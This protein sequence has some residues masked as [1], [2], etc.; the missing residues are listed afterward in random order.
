[1]DGQMPLTGNLYIFGDSLS[2]DG[3]TAT[4]TGQEP[5]PFPFGGRASNGLVWHEYIRNDLAVAPAAST[6]SAAPD[7][8]GLLGGSALNGVN[9]AHGGA[10]ASS[11]DTP[12][13]PGGVQQAEG[14]TALVEAGEIPVPDDQDVFVIWIGGNDFLR[15]A[16]VDLSDIFD[17]LTTGASV[18]GHIA[19]MV[20]TLTAVGA[21]N[22][23]VV[24]LPKAG[25]AFLGAEAADN[26]ILATI[27]NELVA[28][29]NRRLEDYVDG[30]DLNALFV[31]VASLIDAV[32]DDPAAFGFSNVSSDIFTDDAEIDD[33]SYFSVDGIHPTSA[34]HAVIANYIRD[35]AAAAGFDLTAEAGNVLP[36]SDRDDQLT[37][38]MGDDSLTG[39]AGD[40]V[41]DGQ[42]GAD[43]AFFAGAQSQFTLAIGPSLTLEDRSGAEGTDT[44]SGIE[45]LDFGG[46]RFDLSPF[47]DAARLSPD[48]FRSLTEVYLSYFNR[49]PDA[50]G[51]T[52]WADAFANGMALSEI[53]RL[54]DISEEAASVFTDD[55]DVADVV[56]EVYA[57]TLGR[58][59]DEDGFAFW[60]TVLESGAVSRDVFILEVLQGARA[61]QPEGASEAFIAQQ[62][63]DRAYLDTKI[64]LGLHYAAGLGLSDVEAASE[65]MALYDG[66]ED[67][68]AAA[69]AVARD[70]ADAA[71][72]PDGSGA[73]LVTLVG[74]VDDPYA[75]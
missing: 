22:V 6:I 66:S 14:F 10:V 45:L 46:D 70:A 57:N 3:A 39:G 15:L 61:D 11:E 41:L 60:R 26:P 74:V 4:Q 56:T 27:W 72:S 29:Y 68:V 53:V 42:D 20:E 47:D 1:M 73:F 55:R 52:F 65:M 9:F 8:Q 18:V 7:L 50:L 67:G 16:E 54:F 23:L 25:G 19:Q 44:L 34:G 31:D 32:E 71:L 13:R 75:V 35:V 63:A 43:I 36:G 51:L 21:Q 28:D 24:G 58:A 2:D 33:Q 38:T 62:A 64:D 48:A 69:L 40:D 59:P 17:I 5:V 12:S 37:G 30:L 49:A